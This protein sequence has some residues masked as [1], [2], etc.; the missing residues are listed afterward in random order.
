LSC[1]RL[2]CQ[3]RPGDVAAQLL[4]P[5]ALVRFDPHGRVQ[6]ETVDV[7]TQK[8]ARQT[9][10]RHRARSVKTFCPARGPKAMR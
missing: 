10:A 1:T 6:A 9:K 4:Q 5:L 8:L 3:R 7:G 2:V